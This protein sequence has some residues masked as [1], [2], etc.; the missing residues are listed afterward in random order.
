MMDTTT[1]EEICEPFQ[2]A[3]GAPATLALADLIRLCV[4]HEIAPSGARST[5]AADVTGVAISDS[6]ISQRLQ[7]LDPALFQTVLDQTLR[8]LAQRRRHP[9]AFYQQ[10]RLVEGHS[11]FFLGGVEEAE[12]RG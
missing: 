1:I 12:L 6:A 11:P 9:Q 8:P 7:S 3:R 5:H 4:Y 2:P 10:W